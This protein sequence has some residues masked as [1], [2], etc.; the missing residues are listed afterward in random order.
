MTSNANPSPERIADPSI[1][2]TKINL[3]WLL[4]LRWAAACGQAL[5][6]AV[7]VLWYATDLPFYELS[8]IIA[9]S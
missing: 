7:A 6:I 2:R 3:G 1:E 5:T 4:R 9:S 8:S